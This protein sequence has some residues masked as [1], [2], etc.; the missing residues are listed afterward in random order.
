[1]QGFSSITIFLMVLFLLLIVAGLCI[2]LYIFLWSKPM[3][4]DKKKTIIVDNQSE[5]PI[6]IRT[7]KVLTRIAGRDSNTRKRTGL[8]T[9]SM[10]S[11]MRNAPVPDN[12]GKRAS[13]NVVV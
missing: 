5:S 4:K 2:V 8:Q 6:T 10:S 13:D 12:H 11:V 3:T 7:E 9:K 1:M